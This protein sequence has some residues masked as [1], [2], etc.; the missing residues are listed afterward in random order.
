MATGCWK[1][2]TLVPLG[3]LPPVAHQAIVWSLLE[4]DVRPHDAVL[5]QGA[6]GAAPLCWNPAVFAKQVHRIF[7]WLRYQTC[8]TSGLKTRHVGMMQT[9]TLY[10]VDYMLS[11]I[12][13]TSSTRMASAFCLPGCHLRCARKRCS[14]SRCKCGARS[15]KCGPALQKSTRVCKT[16]AS[17]FQ[18]AEMPD[19]S[20]K[21][22]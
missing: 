20:Y 22:T 8:L 13:R 12:W 9:K 7:S 4:R 15:Q 14:A 16:S 2:E 1:F 11:K 10:I 19:S 5:E 17:Y 3:W 21:W 6:R 18:S